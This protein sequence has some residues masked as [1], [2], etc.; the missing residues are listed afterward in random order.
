[1]SV[2][3]FPRIHFRGTVSWDPGLANNRAELFDA[4]RVAVRLPDGVTFGT[5]VEHIIDQLPKYG[6][7]NYTGTSY[8]PIR[9][10]L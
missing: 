8:L 10:G 7:W 1:M 2:L 3:S 4:K 5:F 6:I 9:G